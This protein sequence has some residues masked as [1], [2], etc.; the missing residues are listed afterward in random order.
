MVFSEEFDDA[1]SAELKKELKLNME[2]FVPPE[3][4]AQVTWYCV[5]PEPGRNGWVS[6][7]YRPR[8]DG[9]APPAISPT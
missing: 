8:R 7:A 3:Y 2:G 4:R 5:R 1:N 6:W 9:M